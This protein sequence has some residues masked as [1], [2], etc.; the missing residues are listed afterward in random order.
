[1][2][3]GKQK[4]AR[5]RLSNAYRSR[6]RRWTESLDI[7]HRRKTVAP[8][9]RVRGEY[10]WCRDWLLQRAS[11]R[12]NFEGIRFASVALHMAAIKHIEHVCVGRA[13]SVT[14]IAHEIVDTHPRP[15]RRLRGRWWR[16]AVVPRRKRLQGAVSLGRRII[17]SATWGG[18]R[19]GVWRRR[20]TSTFVRICAGRRC[21]AR[22]MGRI[23]RL[24]VVLWWRSA[25]VGCRRDR[26]RH[27]VR[28][29]SQ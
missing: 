29:F 26:W 17:S 12:A 11:P 20:G 6:K 1:M 28:W 27:S 10:H 22:R 18:G 25:R 14:V 15:A 9:F 19:L 5:M 23:V 13:T 7:I 2:R 16:C 8:D 4:A 21:A 3:P 24:L